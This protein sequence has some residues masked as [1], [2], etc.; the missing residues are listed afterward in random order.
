[1]IQ[2]PLIIN[3]KEVLFFSLRKGQRSFQ[4]STSGAYHLDEGSLGA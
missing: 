1:M 3:P 2:Y 4:S